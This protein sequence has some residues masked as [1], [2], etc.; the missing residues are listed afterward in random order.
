MF[1]IWLEM[2]HIMAIVEAKDSNE[3]RAE[4]NKRINVRKMETK[5]GSEE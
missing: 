5:R 1:N 2:S 4:F 3:A